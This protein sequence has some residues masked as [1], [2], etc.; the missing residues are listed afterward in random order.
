MFETSLS[1]AVTQWGEETCDKLDH[2][3]YTCWQTLKSNFDPSW[4]PDKTR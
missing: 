2:T 3:Y 4:K 1:M